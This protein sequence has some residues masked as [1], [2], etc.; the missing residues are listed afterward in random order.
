MIYIGLFDI[1]YTITMHFHYR[2]KYRGMLTKKAIKQ[3]DAEYFEWMIDPAN[4]Y[5]DDCIFSQIRNKRFRIISIAFVT[6]D[7]YE[8]DVSYCMDDIGIQIIRLRFRGISDHTGIFDVIS[9]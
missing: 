5:G 1:E 2:E 4:R 8:F 7:S 6:N 3:L 9:K